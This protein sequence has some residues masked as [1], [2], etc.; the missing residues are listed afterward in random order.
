MATH[1]VPDPDHNGVVVK[2]LM[3]GYRV[4]GRV[5]RPSRVVIGAY[6]EG[7]PALTA[8]GAD[9]VIG[10][11]PPATPAPAGEGELSLEEIVAQA[12]AQLATSTALEPAAKDDEDEGEPS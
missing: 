10:N 8:S 3:R 9:R 5:V 7:A 11:E 12:E 6:Q 1:P 2:E 4:N